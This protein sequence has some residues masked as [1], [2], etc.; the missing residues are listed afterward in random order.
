MLKITTEIEKSLSTAAS[1]LAST[2][3]TTQWQK[4]THLTTYA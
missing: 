1:K 3:L 4:C 2:V